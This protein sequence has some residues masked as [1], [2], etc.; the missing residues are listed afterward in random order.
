MLK[1]YFKQQLR[2]MSL[3]LVALGGNLLPR[4]KLMWC[5]PLKVYDTVIF[6]CHSHF[7][8]HFRVTGNLILLC[9]SSVW[10]RWANVFVSR[11]LTSCEHR[12]THWCA[13]RLEV[14][15]IWHQFDIDTCQNL[16]Q[17]N[18][19]ALKL[20]VIANWLPCPSEL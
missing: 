10:I 20:G 18:Q 12:C 3:H 15:F 5:V 11:L 6:V 16:Q 1:K 17:A 2:H 14:D 9:K 13:N 8:V 7:G 19:C 4:F